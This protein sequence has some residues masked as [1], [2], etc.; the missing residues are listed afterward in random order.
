MSLMGGNG[1]APKRPRGTMLWFN[2]AKDHGVIA[3]DDGRL[4]VA[5]SAFEG[6][7]PQGPC[8]GLV[9]EFDLEAGDDGPRP[10]RV[11][12]VPEPVAAHRARRRRSH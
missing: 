6:E 10:E 1:R 7:P 12:L 9:V 8:S 3:T 11:R 2:E 5:G 4:P